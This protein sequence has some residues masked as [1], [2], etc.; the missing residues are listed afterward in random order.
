MRIDWHKTEG[1]S[2]EAHQEEDLKKQALPTAIR[3]KKGQRK[4][5]RAPKAHQRRPVR[6]QKLTAPNRAVGPRKGE[7]NLQ[8][9]SR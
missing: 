4:K 5:Q 7:G 3:Q 6:P 9:S 2:F 1:A 8:L